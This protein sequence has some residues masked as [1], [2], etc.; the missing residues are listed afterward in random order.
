MKKARATDRERLVGYLEKRIEKDFS[1][2]WSW[3]NG[4]FV[5]RF[6]S[7]INH[8]GLIARFEVRGFE[9][10]SIIET[11]G[12]YGDEDGESQTFNLEEGIGA[13][14]R[15]TAEKLAELYDTVVQ[16]AA[17]YLEMYEKALRGAI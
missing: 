8:L 16:R 7:F 10:R 12:R 17:P 9:L 5:G 4:Y 6:A 1:R 3:E 13:C 11:K 15:W 14:A 2:C